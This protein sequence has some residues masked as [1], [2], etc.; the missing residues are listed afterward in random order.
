MRD[1]LGSSVTERK[2]FT[3]FICLGHQSPS[4]FT[5]RPLEWSDTL[6]VNNPTFSSILNN[7]ECVP[8]ALFVRSSLVLHPSLPTSAPM[9]SPGGAFIPLGVHFPKWS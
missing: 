9:L 6:K 7:I 3:F 5:Y 1:V 2:V 8:P 4:V